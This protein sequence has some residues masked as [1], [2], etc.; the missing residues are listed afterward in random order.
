M[1][2]NSNTESRHFEMTFNAYTCKYFVYYDSVRLK[3]LFVILATVKS[4]SSS[5]LFFV[6]RLLRP[7]KDQ[8]QGKAGQG[9]E[10]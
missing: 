2:S 4:S 8:A 7:P 1:P 10:S 3:L 5:I 6:T 9:V